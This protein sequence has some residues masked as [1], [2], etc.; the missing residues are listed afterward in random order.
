MN[1]TITRLLE[2]LIF[3]LAQC[4]LSDSNNYPYWHMF[5]GEQKFSISGLIEN[6]SM[7]NSSVLETFTCKQEERFEC[8]AGDAFGKQRRFPHPLFWDFK[9][10]VLA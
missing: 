9:V 3:C 6:V 4:D 10:T 1:K 8:K 7:S 2:R 5:N